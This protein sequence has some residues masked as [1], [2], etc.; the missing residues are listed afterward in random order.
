MKH[1]VLAV[2]VVSVST[3]YAEN[4]RYEIVPYEL[5]NNGGDRTSISGFIETDAVIGKVESSNIVDFEVRLRDEFFSMTA[6]RDSCEELAPDCRGVTIH[7][8]LWATASELTVPIGG[9]FDI[10]VEID[11]PSEVIDGVYVEYLSDPERFVTPEGVIAL[12]VIEGERMA[13]L[14]SAY[15]WHAFNELKPIQVA[16]VTIFPDCNQD[17]LVDIQDANCT[18]DRMLDEFLAGHATLRGDLDG[19]AGVDFADF[20]SFSR[21]FGM[22]PASYTDGD[23]NKDGA[24]GF[25]DFLLLSN[26]YAQG[27]DF[28]GAVA[29]V[30]ES[31]LLGLFTAW[32]SVLVFSRYKSRR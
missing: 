30:P 13:E 23:F 17:G 16:T 26:N 29:T 4:I 32:I 8:S 14:S 6:I 31:S 1:A 7:G 22:S 21:S 9:S 11:D 10:L 19:M 12:G 24:V 20:V 2:V 5:V 28:G 25:P 15:F 3:V 18:P 27:N